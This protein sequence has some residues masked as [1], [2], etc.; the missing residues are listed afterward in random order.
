MGALHDVKR[1]LAR[2]TFRRAALRAPASS[3]S[4]GGGAEVQGVSCRGGIH[5]PWGFSTEGLGTMVLHPPLESTA[6]TPVCPPGAWDAASARSTHR[7]PTGVSCLHALSLGVAGDLRLVPFV[8]RRPHQA[9][10]RRG[11]AR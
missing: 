6:C 10:G 8:L 2:R 7:R 9:G 3:S 11:L 1:T 5:E 4:W